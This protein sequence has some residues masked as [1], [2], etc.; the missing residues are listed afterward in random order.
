[1]RPFFF[2]EVPKI[3]PKIDESACQPGLP[4]QEEAVVVGVKQ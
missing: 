1:M 4:Q 2:M 3:N